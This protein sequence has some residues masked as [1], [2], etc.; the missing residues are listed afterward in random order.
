[1]K[2]VLPVGPTL[3]I[4]LPPNGFFLPVITTFFLPVLGPGLASTVNAPRLVGLFKLKLLVLNGFATELSGAP[5]I[6]LFERPPVPPVPALIT[7]P[8]C[9]GRLSVGKGVLENGATG[10]GALAF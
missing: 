8:H 9:R 4:P 2:D 5:A 1:M 7:S 10:G 3:K 6:G